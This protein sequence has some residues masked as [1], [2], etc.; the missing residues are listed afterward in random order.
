MENPFKWRH[1]QSEIILLTVRWYLRYALS[2]LA[3][4]CFP[5]LNGLPYF[6]VMRHLLEV[7][8]LSRG[9]NL[10]PLCSSLRAGLRFL[11]H[12]LPAPPLAHLTVR[13]PGF[14]GE[15]R[16]YHVPVEYLHGLGL[17]YLPMVQRL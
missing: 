4:I 7:C 17:A 6:L 10:E 13:F 12:P 2:A 16:A 1:Y 5:T 11:Q 8:P 9:T 3:V 14:P 15:I